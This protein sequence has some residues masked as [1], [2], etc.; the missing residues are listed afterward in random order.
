MTKKLYRSQEKKMIGGVCAGLAKYLDIDAT[1]IR[2][3]FVGVGL[4]T[5]VFPMFIFYIIA[6]I[7]IPVEE[8]AEA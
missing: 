6:W 8:S 2:L 5:A 1:V 7:I 4:L 3:L